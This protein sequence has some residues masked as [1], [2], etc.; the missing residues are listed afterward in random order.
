MKYIFVIFFFSIG[1]FSSLQ[2]QT[3]A[4][5]ISGKIANNLKDSLQLTVIQRNAVFDINMRL[6]V[7]KSDVRNKYQQ[8][9]SMRIYMQ[10]V[11]NTRD[12][13]YKA[14]LNEQQFLQYKKRKYTLLNVN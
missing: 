6:A 13:L 9:D 12:S 4:E 14:I 1:F 8:Q 5:E 7:A 3:K 2:A 11:E 10:R